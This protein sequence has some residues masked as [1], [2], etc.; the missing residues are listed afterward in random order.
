MQHIINALLL[1]GIYATIGIGFSLVY[2]VMSIINLAHG[3]V[4]MLGS[5]ITF[6]VFDYM[7][8]DPFIS[9]PIVLVATFVIGYVIQKFII[10]KVVKW[11]LY[12]TVV[13]TFGLDLILV[14]IAMLIWSA[15]FRAVVPS[16]TGAGFSVGGTVIPYIRLIIFVLTFLLTALLHLF[17]TKTRTGQ[18]IRATSIN[19]EAAQLAGVEI[20]K[21][22]AITFGIGAALAGAAG[23]MF[24]MVYSIHPSMGAPFLSRAFAIAVLGG[25][26]NVNGAI[27]GGL[28]LAFAETFGSLV[29]GAGYQQ[30]IGLIILLLVL[31]VRPQGLVGHQFS[32]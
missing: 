8:I 14:N 20:E 1:G 5:Y 2:G 11:G 10:N 15:D 30:A 16:Y 3:S 9:I 25:L 31:I 4:I 29:F 26:G 13:L 7:G 6:C 19:M 32:K 23:A 12:M 21:I 24:S 27:V 28:V 17:M 22:Y 18:A